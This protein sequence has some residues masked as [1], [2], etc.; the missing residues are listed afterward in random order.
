MSE[1]AKT[2]TGKKLRTI[3]ERI[4][5]AGTAL[6]DW[7][8]LDVELSSRIGLLIADERERMLAAIAILFDDRNIQTRDSLF[9]ALRNVVCACPAPPSPVKEP[10]YEPATVAGAMKRLR[11][12]F[13]FDGVPEGFDDWAGVEADLQA[14]VDAAEKSSLL[15]A[16]LHP[17]CEKRI[18]CSG[19]KPEPPAPVPATESPP[20]PPPEPMTVDTLAERLQLRIDTGLLETGDHWCEV[21]GDLTRLMQAQA[22][23]DA[24]IAYTSNYSGAIL[25]GDILRAAGLQ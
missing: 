14:L 25:A 4:V 20:A 7:D 16:C 12:T 24:E 2:P 21:K 15:I 23:R 19:P 1:E 9:A 10:T 8:E 18:R 11:R 6:R 22:T 17:V 3:R 5:A 13:G